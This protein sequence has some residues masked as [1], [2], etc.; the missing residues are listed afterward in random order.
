[1]ILTM[2]HISIIGLK[3]QRKKVLERLQRLESV[4]IVDIADDN[5][6]LQ[7]KNTSN[8]IAVFERNIALADSALKIIDSR[9]PQKKRLFAARRDIT[10]EQ[11]YKKIPEYEAILK[12]CSDITD[13]VKNIEESKAA[14]VRISNQILT[15]EP[16]S[17]LEVPMNY[18]GT[19][20]TASFIGTIPDNIT[21]EQIAEKLPDLPDS[22]QIEIISSSAE[23]TCIWVLAHRSCSDKVEEQLRKI[24]FARPAWSL[25]HLRCD[26]KIRRL[27]AEIEQNNE[28]AESLAQKLKDYE[29]DRNDIQFVIDYLT[30]RRDKYDTIASLA[31]TDRTFILEGWIPHSELDKLHKV[32]D[33]YDVYIETSDPTEDEDIPVK[34]K[35]GFFVSPVEN[36]TESYDMPG[37]QDI[38]PNPFMAFFY[39]LLFGLMLSDAGYGLLMAIASG[40]FAFVAK[41]EEKTKR[42]MRMFFFCSLSTIFWG[43]IFGSWFGDLFT[44][45]A[46]DFFNPPDGATIA[47]WIDPLSE[48]MK[49][50]YLSVIIGVIHI[51]VG[52]IAKF[53]A[54]VKHQTVFDAIC[55]AGFQIIMLIGGL[56]GVA[57][58]MLLPE[59]IIG[60]VG[61]YMAIGGFVLT[62]LLSARKSKGFAIFG[63]ILSGV[64]NLV[65]GYLSDILSYTRLMALC[66]TTGAIGMVVNKLATMFGNNILGYILFALIF[67]LG[68]AINLGINALGTYV[69]CNRLQYVEFFKQFYEGG[70]RAFKPFAVNTKYVKFKEEI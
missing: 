40:F 13:C 15:L 14:A 12:K 19:K 46:T 49:L 70:G 20:S 54:L 56:A 3:T 66:L 64:Y 9:F 68:H 31:M 34:F 35:N 55:D 39:Y 29:Q 58:M 51:M 4:E 21:L 60:T 47:V 22:V 5:L 38:D 25:S 36:L 48:P 59:T 52:L 32:L 24:G 61:I 18:K 41:V 16:W 44:R 7:H 37:K 50:I 28:Q 27:E 26:E 62:C 63:S 53:V 17:N 30:M 23:Q 33:K 69:H 6:E 43:M 1:M 11:Y 10:S 8:E 2:K 42:T 65:T 45:I 67:V 57:G